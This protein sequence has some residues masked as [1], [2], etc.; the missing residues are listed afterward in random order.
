MKFAKYII[1]SCILSVPVLAADAKLGADSF[2]ANCADCHSVAK[3]LKNKKGPGLTG[4][5]NRKAGTVDGY[6]YSDAMKSADFNW[7]LEKLDAYIK[8]PKQVVPNDKMKFKGL[9]DDKERQDLIAFLQEQ[10]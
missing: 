9:A 3:P 8:N 2:D 4:V 10:Q 6:N 7:T 5:V 1:V